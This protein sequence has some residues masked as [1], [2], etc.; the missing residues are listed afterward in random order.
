MGEPEYT[1]ATITV[2]YGG[3]PV[4]RPISRAEY[5]ARFDELLDDAAGWTY[6]H[7]RLKHKSGVALWVGNGRSWLEPYTSPGERCPGFGF[8]G[9]IRLWRKV[10]AVHRAILVRKMEVPRD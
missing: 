7:N 1:S 4:E 9:K 2:S 8:F 5:V 6:E 10:E 3:P